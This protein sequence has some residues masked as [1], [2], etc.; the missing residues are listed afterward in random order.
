MIFYICGVNLYFELRGVNVRVKVM[1]SSRW[2]HP[3]EFPTFEKG[4]PIMVADDEDTDFLGWYPC[5]I[6]GYQSYV[7]KKFVCDG[8]LARDYNPTELIQEA[9]DI[10][11]V[12]E[13]AFAW[14][15]ATNENGVTGWIPA[16]CVMSAN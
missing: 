9:G 1:R 14:L 4:T 6:I 16:E 11:E 12:Q 3:G 13:I 15:L 10:L 2:E 8:K 7:P 5:E